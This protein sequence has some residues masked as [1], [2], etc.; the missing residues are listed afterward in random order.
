MTIIVPGL[1]AGVAS[2]VQDRTLEREF[3]EALYPNLLFR[4]EARP[5]VWAANIGERVV[6]TRAGRMQVDP[7]PLQP[8]VDPVPKGYQFEQWEAVAAQYGDSID[9]HMP[10]SHVT[11]ASLLLQNIKTLGGNAGETVNVLTRNPLFR[12]YLGGTTNLIAAGV[13][14]ASTIRVASINGFRRA[15]TAAGTAADVG[16]A[17]PIAVSF[18]TAEPDNSVIGA[19]PDN[20]LQPDG[21]GTLFLSTPLTGAVALRAGVIAQTRSRIQRVGGGPTVDALTGA[22]ILTLQDIINAVARLRANDVPPQADGFFHVHVTAE[23]EA[24]LFADNAFQRLFQ[25]L[26]DSMPFRD[27]AIAQLIGC[28]FFRNTQVPNTLNAGPLVA[29]DGGSGSA[30]CAPFIG[31]E[32]V[33]QAGLA[34]KRA[35][36]IGG[37]ALVEKYLDESKFISEAGVSGMIGGFSVTQNGLQVMTDRIR[38]I[39]RAPQDRLQQVVSATWSWSGDFPV[40]SDART[41]DEALFKRAI[42]IEHA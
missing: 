7:T 5:E 14:A 11:L 8:G 30:R 40:P 35:I 6:F 28:R 37:A 4:S 24:Q 2:I 42:V 36:V 18:T 31:A 38:L 13:G 17:N 3:K 15:L 9:T 41:G 33:N 34:V 26:P 23:G 1:P 29:T 12:A 25:S 10:T 22:N 20:A 39:L 19:I 16:P 21:P 32:V 27:L